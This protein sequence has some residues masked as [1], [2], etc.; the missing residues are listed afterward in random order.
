MKISQGTIAAA[1]AGLAIVAAIGTAASGRASATP[2]ECIKIAHIGSEDKPVGSLRL[3]LGERGK[4]KADRIL[5]NEWSFEF[6]AA[7]FGGL[8]GFVSTHGERTTGH[9]GTIKFGT[10]LVTWGTKSQEKSALVGDSSACQYLGELMKLVPKRDYVQFFD[11][12]E[13]LTKRLQCAS[14]RGVT[15]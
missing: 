13:N 7:T 8:K 12:L 3:C 10:F 4:S 11:V 2:E 6:D 14:S 15:N 5:A 1:F 9:S